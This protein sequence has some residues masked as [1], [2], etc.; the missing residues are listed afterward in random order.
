MHPR[1]SCVFSFAY[2]GVTN[3]LSI[4]YPVLRD[5]Y[6]NLMC[7]GFAAPS[8]HFTSLEE[9]IFGRANF[10]LYVCIQVSNCD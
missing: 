4:A 3:L 8:P 6:N 1:L 9:S 5:F 2:E 10:L 7:I